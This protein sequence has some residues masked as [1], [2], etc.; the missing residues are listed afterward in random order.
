MSGVDNKKDSFPCLALRRSSSR[1]GVRDVRRLPKAAEPLLSRFSYSVYTPTFQR[2]CCCSWGRC[3]RWAP[4]RHRAP[5][6]AACRWPSGPLHR[7]PPRLL[8]RP[9]VAV[10]AGQGAGGDGAG[11]GAGGRAGG[12]P[13]G[14]HRRRSTRAST[15]TAR[16]A[17]ATPAARPAATRLGVGPQVG[18]AGGQRPASPSPR[19]PG[20]C[21]CW[22]RCTAP[23]AEPEGRP[24]AQDADRRWPGS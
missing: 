1:K 24:A 10:A 18:G 6:W 7:L 11:T 14:R 17:T 9:L 21:R 12:L 4:H 5:C 8:P 19:G 23:G 2:A 15:S 3:W 20:R 13:G 16:A 22:R